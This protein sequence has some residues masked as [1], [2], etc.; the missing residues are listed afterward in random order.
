MKYT[1]SCLIASIAI[2][3]M[4]GAQDVWVRPYVFADDASSNFSYNWD[5]DTQSLTLS[6]MSVDANPFGREN[7]WAN[8]H[9]WFL[10]TNGIGPSVFDPTE[11]FE[12]SFTMNL[13]PVMQAN[14]IAEA[15]IHLV[16][17]PFPRIPGTGQETWF[18]DGYLLVANEAGG[19]N[20]G[21]IAAFGGRMPFWNGSGARY[22]GGDITLTFRYDPAA[23]SGAGA[24]QYQVDYNGNTYT[25]AS[26]IPGDFAGLR[27][28]QIGAWVQVNRINDFDPDRHVLASFKNIRLNGKQV[29]GQGCGDVN[30]DG[31]VDDVDLLTVLF[32]FGLGG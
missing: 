12:F 27:Y 14:R 8:R 24:V 28:F 17:M 7:P 11:P 32:N 25:S 9:V 4:A 15:G 6:D 16:E 23:N 3:A 21:E 26:L 22:S 31:R 2:T 10:S 30:M 18:A 29:V 19:G 5:C 13:S 20:G 1:L